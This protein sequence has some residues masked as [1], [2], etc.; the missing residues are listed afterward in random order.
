MQHPL[1][2]SRRIEYGLRAMVCLAA[3][4][5][6]RVMSFREI[7]RRMTVPQDFLAKILK[8]LVTRRLVAS[9]RGARGGYKLGRPAR[10]IS[11]LEVIEAVEGPVVVNLCQEGHD[12]CRMSRACTLYGVW[13]RG[14]EQMLDVYRTAT[15]D[16]LAMA[17]LRMPEPAQISAA[18]G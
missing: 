4:P 13:K 12:A 16:Q 11:F 18:G 14:Q 7:A 3:Q 17:E 15:L 10:E 1:Q 8:Q 9:T 6:G 5:E 2:I